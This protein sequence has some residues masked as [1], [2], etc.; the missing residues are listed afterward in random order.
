MFHV[1]RK[2]NKNN[3]K[4]KT[5]KRVVVLS[6]GGAKGRI[7]IVALAKREK[8]VGELYKYYDLMVGTSVGSI[9]A[10]AIASGNIT[11]EKMDSLYDDILSKVF[12]KRPWYQRMILPKY[13]RK[14]FESIW[15]DLIGNIKMNRCKTKLLITSVDRCTDRNH[16]FK[17]WTKDGEQLLVTEVMKSFAAPFYFGQYNDAQAERVWFD[18]GVGTSNLSLEEALMEAILLGWINE[19]LQVDVFGCGYV[20]TTIPYKEAC[21]ESNFKQLFDFIKPIEG[22][23]ARAQSREDKIARMK[24]IAQKFPNIKFN[25]WD[26]QIQ[27]KYEGMDKLQYLKEY[28][29]YGKIMAQAPIISV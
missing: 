23:L 27:E 10:A 12:M 4:E 8:D 11:A 6:G 19:E 28:K 29:E 7:Q 5:M 16:Y 17:S 21:K 26:V 20:D 13:Q 25:Y 15:K 3:Q 24:I 9:N 14:Y 2:E 1:Y 22:G 18:G